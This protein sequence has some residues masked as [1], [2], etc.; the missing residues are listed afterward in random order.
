MAVVAFHEQKKM[1]RG[2]DKLKRKRR[3][4]MVNLDE[5]VLFN[6]TRR[7]VSDAVGNNETTSGS[8]GGYTEEE[9]FERSL[10]ACMECLFKLHMEWKDVPFF[11]CSAINRRNQ[12]FICVC[13]SRTKKMVRNGVVEMTAMLSIVIEEE[14]KKIRKLTLRLERQ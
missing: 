9:K 12:K 5:Y 11:R 14:S 2:P 10:S 4:R 13:T 8:E 6:W 1:R 7:A 3:R